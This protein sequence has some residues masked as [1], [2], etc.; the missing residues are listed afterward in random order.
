MDSTFDDQLKLNSPDKVR[1]S[2]FYEEANERDL[3]RFDLMLALT[4][5]ER[6]CVLAKLVL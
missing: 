3:S 4:Q 1:S 5:D 2:L 6:D